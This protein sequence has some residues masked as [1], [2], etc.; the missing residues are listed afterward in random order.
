MKA[1]LARL[2]ALWQARSRREQVLVL[3]AA[4]FVLLA[5]G[6]ALLWRPLAEER[7]RLMARVPELAREA[8]EAEALADQVRTKGGARQTTKALLP[9]VEEHLRRL[10]LRQALARLRPQPGSGERFLLELRDAPFVPVV[11][12]VA[13][14][15]EAGVDVV[16]M[17]LERAAPGRA[18]LR[19]VVAR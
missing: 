2:V 12:L 18:H 5:L 9:L 14:L 17:R 1:Q 19:L 6:D 8:D 4:V 11:K 3:V 15:G 10:G 13:A 16:E 7:A